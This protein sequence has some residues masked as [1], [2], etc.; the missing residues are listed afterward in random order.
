MVLPQCRHRATNRLPCSVLGAPSL[1]SGA[2]SLRVS[3]YS[4]VEGQVRRRRGR[5]LAGAVP[6]AVV[7]KDGWSPGPD[8]AMPS[9]LFAPSPGPSSVSALVVSCRPPFGRAVTREALTTSSSSASSVEGSG[10]GPSIT[11]RFDSYF[12][13]IKFS[14]F[15]SDGMWPGASFDSQYLFARAL[16]H[17]STLCSCSSVQVSR[18][19]DLTLL[20]CVPMPRCIPEHRMQMKTPRF[21][22]AHRGS[23][24]QLVKALYVISRSVR[25]FRLQSEHVLLPSSFTRFFSV[26]RFC[27]AR[28]AAG[29]GRRAIVG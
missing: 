10:I 4:V 9:A 27:S 13:R 17:F 19:T 6:V 20:M 15:A 22:L 28:S 16:P 25:L 1:P 23:T 24:E 29:L 7:G 18:S 5:S 21:Q 2:L 11:Q 12:V 3:L 8:A 14:I 26:P